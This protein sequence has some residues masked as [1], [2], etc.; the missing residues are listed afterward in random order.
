MGRHFEPFWG[1]RGR[2][3][4]RAEGGVG[5]RKVWGGHLPDRVS[6]AEK[7]SREKNSPSRDRLHRKSF[8]F[9]F[10]KHDICSEKS[11]F[12]KSPALYRLHC[13]NGTSPIPTLLFEKTCKTIDNNRWID[14]F[15]RFGT[16]SPKKTP[17]NISVLRKSVK[18]KSVTVLLRSPGE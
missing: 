4:A 18:K 7:S 16:L 3:W 11:K 10:V 14:S 1:G 13:P 15:H 2:S 6:N 8:R 5:K 9:V 12:P 17:P